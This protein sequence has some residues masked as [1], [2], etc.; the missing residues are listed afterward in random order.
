M[1]MKPFPFLHACT[2]TNAHIHMKFGHHFPPFISIGAIARVNAAF[3]Q[4]SGPIFLDDMKC[5][6]LEYRLFDCLHSGLEVSNCDHS[7]D[8]GV[9]CIEGNLVVA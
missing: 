2:H 7:R 3:G 9:E 8:A 4:G 6:G 1:C 5:S